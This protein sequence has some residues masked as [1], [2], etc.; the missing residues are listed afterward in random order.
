MDPMLSQLEKSALRS[1][2]G[3]LTGTHQWS[4]SAVRRNH[5]ARIRANQRRAK[6]VDIGKRLANG[7]LVTALGVLAV[8]L[9]TLT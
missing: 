9:M 3:L 1:Q 5:F 7:A 4:V 2:H 8:Y 6:R